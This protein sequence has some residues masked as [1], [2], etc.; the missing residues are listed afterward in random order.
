[1]EIRYDDYLDLVTDMLVKMLSVRSIGQEK[2]A[3][4]VSTVTKELSKN[5][6]DTTKIRSYA[7]LIYSELIKIND[8]NMNEQFG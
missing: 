2:S 4:V 8:K 6:G 5:V 7:P 3:A 1:M